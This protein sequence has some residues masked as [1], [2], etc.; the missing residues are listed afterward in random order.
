MA[1]YV[2]NTA[3]SRAPWCMPCTHTADRTSILLPWSVP[4][5][6]TE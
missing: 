3:L 5:I 4:S 6:H 1:L 2:R